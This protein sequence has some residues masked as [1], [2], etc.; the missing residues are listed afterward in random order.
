MMQ[1]L[2]LR[3]ISLFLIG[4]LCSGAAAASTVSL[5]DAALGKGPEDQNWSYQ[6]FSNPALLGPF[7]VNRSVSAGSFRMATTGVGQAGY[8]RND[9]QL[10]TATGFDLLLEG[11]SV[12]SESHSN[13]N[14]AGFTLIAVGADRTQAVEL[15]FWR[16]EVWAYTPSG[17]NLLKGAT[18]DLHVAIDTSV[19][20][21]YLLKVRDQ[22]WTL[23]AGDLGV[24]LMGALFDYTQTSV[25]PPAP[26]PYI[27]SN[28]LFFGDNALSAQTSVQLARINLTHVPLPSAFWLLSSV[29]IT[30]AG[31]SRRKLG[32]AAAAA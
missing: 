26:N 8:G 19:P 22:H 10:D 27:V 31:W 9:Q 4:L 15:G 23:E 28:A 16:N 1:I 25:N 2:R 32:F 24:V 3:K 30:Y 7:S 12:E 5:Y 6:E 11:L 21:N 18:A 14:R 29:L 17:P 20:R 13:P